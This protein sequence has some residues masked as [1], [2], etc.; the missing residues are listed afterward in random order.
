MEAIIPAAGLGKRLRPLTFS[1]PKHLIKIAGKPILQWVIEH[2]KKLKIKDIVIVISKNSAKI[3]DYF[4]DGKDFGVN[5]SYCYQEKAKGIANAIYKAKDFVSNRFLVYLGDNIVFHDLSKFINFK[6]SAAILLAKVKHPN[7]FG[8]AE[9][10]NGKIVR[11]VEKPKEYISDLA[12]VGVY[13]FTDEI[14]EIIE[15]LKISWRSEIE[16]TDAIQKLIELNR[17]VEYEIIN[18]W[19]KDTGT[20]EDI[21][22][23]N[24]FLLNN[25]IDN[26][27][28][29]KIEN[30]DIKNKSYIEEDV[31]I[32]NSMIEGP[33]VIGRGTK[34]VNSHIGP[35]VSIGSYCEIVESKIKESVVLDSVIIKNALLD[36]SLIGSFSQIEKGE[37]WQKLIIGEYSYLI[38]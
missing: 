7:R 20:P 23:A 33:V 24:K 28:L 36:N 3:I 30:S 1:G 9:I 29:G 17:E 16:I 13:G 8:V 5:I 37:N 14:F 25:F 10:K 32:K 27:I 2:L 35:Y 4:G 18:G 26:K 12:L 22:E 19:W 6:G 21:L 34:I 15:K 11:L 31:I 38:L